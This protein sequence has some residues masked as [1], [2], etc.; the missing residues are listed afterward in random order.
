MFEVDGHSVSEKRFNDVCAYC[1]LNPFTPTD[2][3]SQPNTMDGRL[4]TVLK[5]LILQ[6]DPELS[7]Q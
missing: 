4:H 3:L 7:K 5:G 6:H 2:D 1:S